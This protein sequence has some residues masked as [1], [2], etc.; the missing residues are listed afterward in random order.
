MCLRS[1]STG[2]TLSLHCV[3]LLSKIPRFSFQKVREKDS[4]FSFL[5]L[6]ILPLTSGTDSL[7]GGLGKADEC[8]LTPHMHYCLLAVVPHGS[9]FSLPMGVCVPQVCSVLDVSTLL[10]SLPALANATIGG[11]CGIPP[12][13][14]GVGAPAVLA[15]VLLLVVTGPVC[16]CRAD[17]AR[18]HGRQ[19]CKSA[20][21]VS[22]Q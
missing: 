7:I 6:L 16:D 20:V 2:H 5:Q 1:F 12:S 21:N 14:Y 8:S 9:S 17:R 15:V 13:A 4:T 11:L 19:G 3:A 10:L 22:H 18:V